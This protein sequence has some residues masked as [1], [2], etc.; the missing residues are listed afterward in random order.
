MN[1]AG[2]DYPA[3]ILTVHGPT[4]EPPCMIERSIADADDGGRWVIETSGDPFAF[5]D[6]DANRKRIK[7][8]RFTS[9]M[10][11]EYLAALGGPCRLGARLA[12]CVARRAP[13]VSAN[14]PSAPLPRE[15]CGPDLDSK[16]TRQ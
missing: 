9:G 12:R 10:L 14:R 8:Q 6:V 1:D 4:G 13:V 5:E 7:R 16:M 15:A 3:R 11:Y 2:P